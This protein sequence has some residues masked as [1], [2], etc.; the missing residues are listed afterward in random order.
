MDQDS[1]YINHTTALKKNNESFAPSLNSPSIVK[2]WLYYL[3][4]T[5][6][7]SIIISDKIYSRFKF[8]LIAKFRLTLVEEALLFPPLLLFADSLSVSEWNYL[9][10]V[11]FVFVVV[12]WHILPSSFTKVVHI[13]NTSNPYNTHSLTHNTDKSLSM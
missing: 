12:I 2:V 5:Y 6:F 7:M 9:R 1:V 8:V 11:V 13:S 3:H 10:I 4:I